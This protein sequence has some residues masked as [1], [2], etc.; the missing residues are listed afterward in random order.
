M[1]RL[2]QYLR[3]AAL[4]I[5]IAAAPAA[6]AQGKGKGPDE[7][8]RTQAYLNAPPIAEGAASRLLINVLGDVDGLLLDNGT[9]VTFPPHMGEQLAAAVKTGDRVVVKGYPEFPGQIKGYVITNAGSQQTVMVL[10]KPPGGKVP[11]HLR[12]AGLK[13]MNAQGEVRQVR[14]GGKG[15]INGVILADGTIVRFSRDA[16]YQ[17]MHLFKVGQGIVA[18]GYGTENPHGRAIEASALG[19]L[20]ATP[21]PLYTP[22]R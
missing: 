3:I 17:F 15:E 20:G 1:T 4:A 6:I 13:E 10:P 22:H 8:L 19:P 18:H 14:R 11:A 12:G 5:G 21:K 2:D 9:I 7:Y 16:S